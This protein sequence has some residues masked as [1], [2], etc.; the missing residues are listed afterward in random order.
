MLYEIVLV[1]IIIPCFNEEKYMSRCLNSVIA[2]DYPKDKL[3]ILIIDGLSTDKTRAIIKEYQN[4]YEFI[5]LIDNPNRTA[6]YALNRGIMES[7]GRVIV[8]L[9]AHCVYPKNYLTVLT[10]KLKELDADNVG[11][12]L[13]TLSGGNNKICQAI[14]LGSSHIF[15]VGNS[16]FRT[17][18]KEIK[19]VDT[20]PFGCYR[21]DVF[22]KIG[23]FDTD[24]IRNQD[25]EFNARIK[26]NGGKIYLIPEVRIDYYA[27]DSLS[28]MM[29]MFYQYGLFKPLVNKKIGAP[30]TFRQLVP[31][32]FVAG[33]LAGLGFSI[34]SKKIFLIYCTILILYFL[35]S[36]GFS[37]A[38]S[39]K[40]KNISLIYL[41][42]VV[43]FLIHLSYG[44]GYIEGL[45]RFIILNKKPQPVEI[46]R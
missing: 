15:G 25:D 24:L 43:F 27:R 10:E 22:D 14:A 3:E 39:I 44:A 38:E 9:D 26:R 1:T 33:L 8:R 37:V 29:A 41:L 36:L 46:N 16:Y 45:I 2:Q 17:G 6:P 42:P 31:P 30:A 19:E 34:F 23:L 7:K 20:V 32:I 35:L 4:N 12:V 5:K 18:A 13:N 11:G 21:R 40:R 28:K